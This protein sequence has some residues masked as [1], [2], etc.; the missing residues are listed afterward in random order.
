MTRRQRHSGQAGFTS[1]TDGHPLPAAP[2]S[3]NSLAAIRGAF[4]DGAGIVE[5]DVRLTRDGVPVLV[6]DAAADRTTDGSGRVAD[7]TYAQVRGLRLRERLG[8]KRT[9]LTGE[10]VPSGSRTRWTWSARGAAP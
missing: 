2:C 3:E 9:A 4:A 8:G 10:R 5:V 1:W 7:L 6:H